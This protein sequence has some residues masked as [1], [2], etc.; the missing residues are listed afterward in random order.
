M[1]VRMIKELQAGVARFIKSKSATL[2]RAICPCLRGVC[3][4]TVVDACVDADVMDR[5]RN[6][7]RVCE[8]VGV[9][10]SAVGSLEGGCMLCSEEILPGVICCG[11]G[12][13]W[14]DGWK[15]RCEVLSSMVID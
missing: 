7:E 12:E 6:L 8:D 5:W 2:T 4:R 15:N 13:A 10:F 9:R 11:Q 3:M 14:N 1:S